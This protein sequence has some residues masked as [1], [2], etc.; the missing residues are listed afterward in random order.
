MSGIRGHV[1]LLMAAAQNST[2]WTP[3]NLSSLVA[4]YAADEPLNTLSSGLMDTLYD[5]S[6][7]GNHAAK[8]A[9]N[10]AN[11]GQVYAA[12][13]NGLPVWG[14]DTTARQAYFR[15]TNAHVLASGNAKAGISI[16][17]MS[18]GIV[19]HNSSIVGTIA[20]LTSGTSDASGRALLSRGSIG[21][22]TIYGGGRRLDSDSLQTLTDSINYGTGYGIAGTVLDYANSDGFAWVNGSAAGSSTSFQTSGN[23]SATNSQA[24]N[25][26]ATGA[27][28]NPHL[29][30]IGEIILCNTALGTSD[31][32]K[33]E[34]Y[35]AHRWG[36]TSLLPGGHPYKTTAP[37][38]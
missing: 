14:Y 34:G 23:T 20:N 4:W 6:G 21:L 29:G 22:N 2:P 32:Q 24:W 33:L 37:T 31:R 16:F 25:I 36:L 19:S 17:A 5:K 7:N 3:T 10:T 30:R 38:V 35:L 8:Y 18:A 15:S 1:A 26:G 28:L 9:G 13:Q 11:R 12:E 27:N